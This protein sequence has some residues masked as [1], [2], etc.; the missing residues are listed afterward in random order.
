MVLPA[1]SWNTGKGQVTEEHGG[2]QEICPLE[3]KQEQFSEG[4]LLPE[5]LK[6]HMSTECVVMAFLFQNV[7]NFQKEKKKTLGGGLRLGGSV[8]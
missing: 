4:E 7:N 2:S 1:V 8:G 6:K 5:R 3:V